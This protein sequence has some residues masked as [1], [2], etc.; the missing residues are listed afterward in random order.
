[1]SYLTENMA[2][3]LIVIGLVLMIIEVA[4]IGFATFVLFFVGIAAVLTGLLM[5]VN[6]VPETWSI[7]AAVTA[8]LTLLTA[9]ILWG[10]LKKLQTQQDDRSVNHDFNHHEFTLTEDID[11]RGLSEYSYSGIVW[12][13]KSEQPLAAGTQVHIVR[14]EVGVL[15]VAAKP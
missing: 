7:A 10:P 12:R 15:W 14:S 2:Q 9:A 5:L 4:I 1:M 3:V 6:I 8:V 11:H 13:L